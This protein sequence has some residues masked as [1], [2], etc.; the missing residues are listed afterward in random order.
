MIFVKTHN[1]VLVY[2]SLA[3]SRFYSKQ[4]YEQSGQNVEG[5]FLDQSFNDHQYKVNYLMEPKL[6]FEGKCDKKCS[7]KGGF[8]KLLKLQITFKFKLITLLI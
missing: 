6:S 2:K 3:Y 4:N 5:N 1:L 8:G 7:I